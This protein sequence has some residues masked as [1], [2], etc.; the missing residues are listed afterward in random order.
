MFN[1]LRKI[2]EYETELKDLKD[3]CD[4]S[5]R[6]LAEYKHKKKME[7][8]D[9]KHMRR[10]EL[11]KVKQESITNSIKMEGEKVRAIG[12]VKD[13]YRDKMEERLHKELDNMKE[14]YS[15]ILTRLPNVN[16]KMKG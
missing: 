12:E 9:I 10:I 8:E 6:E 7:E 2:N 13:K 14:M 3:A 15:E 11:E 5:K 4:K 1:K 16:L